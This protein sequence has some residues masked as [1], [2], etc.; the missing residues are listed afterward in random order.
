MPI[1]RKTVTSSN[2][3]FDTKLEES[4]Q[5][6]HPD[7]RSM[8]LP[9]EDDPSAGS[10]TNAVTLPSD[11]P[12]LQHT[13]GVANQSALTHPLCV[14]DSG[15]QQLVPSQAISSTGSAV[16][17]TP[18]GQD[19]PTQGPITRS[20]SSWADVV[21]KPASEPED[22]STK[23]P[24]YTRPRGRPPTNH[25]WDS[26]KGKYVPINNLVTAPAANSAWILAAMHSDLVA[27]HSTPKTYNEAVNGPD[28]EHWIKAVQE[29]LASLR[30]CA[31]WKQVVLSAVSAEAKPIPTK[32]VF[33]IKTDGHGHVARYKARI[34]VCG[35][36]QKFGRD[37]TLTFAPVAHAA[38][39]RMVLA[40]AVSLCL[41]L[42]QFDVKTAFLYG[43]LPEDQRVYLLPPKGV[44]VPPGHVLALL[45]SMYGLKQAPST[46]VE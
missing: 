12:P 44:D 5:R 26:S 38:S 46:S 40:L 34:V 9:E 19:L 10:A 33:K 35:Y 13:T 20:A 16:A 24:P 17:S 32:W 3:T 11:V 45:K 14:R 6:R 8:V 4:L 41:C 31:V 22:A 29:E 28:A 37:Y 43:D 36:R 15:P 30:K 18:L 1:Y 25:N 23:G 42:R 2:V 21:R 39:I 7:L 27:R